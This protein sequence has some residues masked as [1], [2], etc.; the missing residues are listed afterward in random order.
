MDG[1]PAGTDPADGSPAKANVL[2]EDGRLDVAD[3]VAVPVAHDRRT[4]DRPKTFAPSVRNS[5]GEGPAL[6]AVAADVT[7]AVAVPVTDERRSPAAPN[8]CAGRLGPGAEVEREPPVQRLVDADLVAVSAVPVAGE[9]DAPNGPMEAVVAD[10]PAE[11]VCH[12]E[13]C[14]VAGS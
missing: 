14:R 5:R 3:T 7:E 11:S 6:R 8:T 4:A 1:R 2:V 10:A 13:N 9:R 12:K